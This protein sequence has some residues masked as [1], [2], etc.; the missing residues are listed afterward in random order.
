MIIV[1]PARSRLL[2]QSSPPTRQFIVAQRETTV[3][4][5]MAR[6]EPLKSCDSVARAQKTLSFFGGTRHTR[7]DFCG[8]APMFRSKAAGIVKSISQ[9]DVEKSRQTM[10]G[11]PLRAHRVAF[12]CAVPRLDAKC[13]I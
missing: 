7:I 11:T 1:F 10:V 6:T 13:C 5:Q 8:F 9:D 3:H 4:R 12:V 2:G